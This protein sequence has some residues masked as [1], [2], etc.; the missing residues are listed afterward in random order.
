MRT[1][2]L[3]L[4]LAPPEKSSPRGAVLG[5]PKKIPLGDRIVTHVKI[6]SFL[7]MSLAAARANASYAAATRSLAFVSPSVAT[8]IKTQ[9]WYPAPIDTREE[10]QYYTS[11]Y[12]G[13]AA[14]NANFAPDAQFPLIVL[15]HG[16]GGTRFDMHY[17]GEALARQGYAVVA[18]DAPG[19][20]AGSYTP[21]GGAKMWFRAKLVSHIAEWL[22]GR[23]DFAEHI[24][25]NRIGLIGHSAG[26]SSALVAAGSE[27][28]GIRFNEAYP[29]SGPVPMGRFDDPNVRGVVALNPGT[30]AAFT[31]EGI[32]KI[33]V[34]ALIFSGDNDHTAVAEKNAEKYASAILNARYFKLEH[35]DH[36]TLMATCSV[37]GRLRHFGSCVDADPLTD[38]DALHERVVHETIEFFKPLL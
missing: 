25:T 6:L 28:D 15:M 14:K 27:V 16:W 19:V 30:G 3:S 31:A 24:A 22:E 9:L 1:A 5:C 34:P 17:L 7:I 18:F 36:Y 29:P 12:W 26:G 8:P 2:P 37:W 38:R 10:R 33:H 23:P 32:A 13:R 4:F 20:A 21:E 11:A 35:C